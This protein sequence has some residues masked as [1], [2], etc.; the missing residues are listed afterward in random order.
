MVKEYKN[1]IIVT[2]LPYSISTLAVIKFLKTDIIKTMYCMLQK[3][4]VERMIAKKSTK[5]F[6]S[7]SVLCQYHSDITKLKFI[8]R[9]LFLPIPDVDSLF[10]KIN[11]NNNLYDAKFANFVKICFAQKRKTIVNNL[12]SLYKLDIIK[13]ALE[14]INKN[15]NVRAEEFEINELLEFYKILSG[16]AKI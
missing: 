15:C 4:V 3:E 11:K 9:E 5:Q 1:P 6:N 7:F 2:N 10:I 8:D 13:S 12:K 14:K 16:L